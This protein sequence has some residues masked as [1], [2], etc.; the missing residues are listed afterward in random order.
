MIDDS[1][2][3]V[4]EET[5]EQYQPL[6]EDLRASYGSGDATK[7]SLARM[8]ERLLQNFA[9]PD[10]QDARAGRILPLANRR[11]IG[12]TAM[13][14][15][16]FRLQIGH[17]WQQRLGALAAVFFTALLVGSLLLL[18]FHAQ[19]SRTGGQPGTG[20]TTTHGYVSL[21]VVPLPSSIPSPA[22]PGN[23]R[24][25]V[26]NGVEGYTEGAG[27][28]SSTDMQVD[29]VWSVL[30]D[31]AGPGK[32]VI[33]ITLDSSYANQN[34][35]PLMNT[36]THECSSSVLQGTRNFPRPSSSVHIQVKVTPIGNVL[37]DVFVVG[38][39]GSNSQCSPL[40]PD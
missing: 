3:F 9:A 12:N 38:C 20:K 29:S 27:N 26:T 14:D 34:N 11:E 31:C 25:L 4:S 32:L 28:I 1:E 40:M 10:I 6:I 15:E 5:E 8:R 39:T 2:E 33:Q 19:Q 17:S 22:L 7:R 23:W 18:L 21:T 37:F 30:S 36:Y 16:G 13:R 35:I 24:V